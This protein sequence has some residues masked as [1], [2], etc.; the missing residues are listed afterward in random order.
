MPS[1]TGPDALA[2]Q[3]EVGARLTGGRDADDLPLP[4]GELAGP[5]PIQ[6][7]I[8]VAMHLVDDPERRD[9]PITGPVVRREDLD[10]PTVE[11]IDASVAF[12][13]DEPRDVGFA[14]AL[15]LLDRG[16]GPTDRAAPNE[17]RSPRPAGT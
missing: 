17:A 13:R 12:E 1:E 5:C 10:A 15:R 9:D 8:A 11:V 6:R 2:G 4:L 14:L 16:N 3:L 7:E